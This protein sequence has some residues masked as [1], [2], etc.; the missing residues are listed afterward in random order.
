MYMYKVCTDR[1]FITNPNKT[2]DQALLLSNK[3]LPKRN[4]LC[5][6]NILKYAPAPHPP[7]TPPQLP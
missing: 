6:Y 7:P 2:E 4:H 3:L 5:E 1:R